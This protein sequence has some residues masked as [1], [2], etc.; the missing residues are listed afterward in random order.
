MRDLID[1][2]V[3]AA[4][5]LSCMF[6]VVCAIV[7]AGSIPPFVCSMALLV[8]VSAGCRAIRAYRCIGR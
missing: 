3:L 8:I 2:L 4:I 6:G 1:F 5:I 7:A